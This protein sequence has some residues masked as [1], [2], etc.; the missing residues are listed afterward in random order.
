MGLDNFDIQE[1][2][3]IVGMVDE[4]RAKIK[5]LLNKIDGG[6][7]VK[8]EEIEGIEKDIGVCLGKLMEIL[9]KESK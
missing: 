6:K 5:L 1:L 4:T 2:Q 8:E 3:K 9:Q 7:D